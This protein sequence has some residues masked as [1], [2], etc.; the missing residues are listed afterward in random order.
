MDTM[1]M[2]LGILDLESAMDSWR[3]SDLASSWMDW[4]D[5]TAR[6]TM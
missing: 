2:I 5:W 1:G 3:Y 6:R 4:M